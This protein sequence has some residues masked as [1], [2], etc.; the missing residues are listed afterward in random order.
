MLRFLRALLAGAA[1]TLVDLAVLAVLV[2]VFGLDPR[3][4]NVPALLAGGAAQFFANRGFVFRATGGGLARQALSFALVEGVALALN[5]VLF[6]A[7]IRLVPPAPF[8]YAIVRL[9]TSHVVFVAWSFPLWRFVF[10]RP[11]PA[12]AV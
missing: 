2:S 9:V 12:H 10:R 3:T 8:A 11:S 7:S 1:A 4:A 5:G 6:D